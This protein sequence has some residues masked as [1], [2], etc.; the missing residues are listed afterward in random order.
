MNPELLILSKSKPYQYSYH[1][2]IKLRRLIIISQQH[3][4]NTFPSQL[5]NAIIFKFIELHKEYTRTRLN[6]PWFHIHVTKSAGTTV[7]RTFFDNFGQKALNNNYFLLR[8]H[9]CTRQYESS[10]I[11]NKVYFHRELPLFTYND[12]I[13]HENASNVYHG[14]SICNKMIYILPFR[15]PL[16][17]ICSQASQI[18][19]HP[20]LSNQNLFRT[21]KSWIKIPG[22][23][24]LFSQQL[25]NPR[26]CEHKNV[27]IS[28]VDYVILQNGRDYTDF[29]YELLSSEKDEKY[30]KVMRS[31][32]ISEPNDIRKR[33][34]LTSKLWNDKELK[35]KWDNCFRFKPRENMVWMPIRFEHDD[36]KSEF[37]LQTMKNMVD[38]SYHRTVSASNVYVS[39]LGFNYSIMDFS[40]LP[41]YV[42]RY[43]V[44]KTHLLNAMDLM[45]RIDYVL[46]FENDMKIDKDNKVWEMA[47]DEIYEYFMYDGKYKKKPRKKRNEMRWIGANNSGKKPGRIWS[48]DICRSLTERDMEWLL[49]F[50]KLDYELYRVAK[51]IALADLSFYGNYTKISL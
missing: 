35:L 49:R 27:S 14:P 34:R 1:D 25:Q 45:L 19:K 4:N 2:F 23:K 10:E 12:Y 13:P 32:P 24:E 46:P 21:F 28:G 36:K 40:V 30:M 7:K 31:T 39:W 37:M 38:I 26:N 42:P 50:N 11:I 20:I 22:N 6:Y 9:N 15:E 29:F 47:L 16:Q 33:I 48:K 17:R 3:L 41:N 18:N 5:Y 43:T 8:D 51:S 44:N